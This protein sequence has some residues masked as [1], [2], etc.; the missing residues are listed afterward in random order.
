MGG[1][2]RARGIERDFKGY[3]IVLDLL[4]F[5]HQLL[6]YNIFRYVIDRANSVKLSVFLLVYMLSMLTRGLKGRE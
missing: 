5:T 6:D 3:R 2:C 4:R 1:Q